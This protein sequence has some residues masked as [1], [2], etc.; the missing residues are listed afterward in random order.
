MFVATYLESI[1]KVLQLTK[2]QK[3]KAVLS[4]IHRTSLYRA[5]I[6]ADWELGWQTLYK[7]FSALRAS[8]LAG[9]YA[10]RIQGD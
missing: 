8:R 5:P 4:M 10:I 9:Q 2:L 3:V 6:F 7:I 1:R